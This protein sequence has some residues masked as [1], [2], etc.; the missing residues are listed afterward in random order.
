MEM[1]LTVVDPQRRHGA[2]ELTVR[3]PP[4][5][6]ASDLVPAVARELGRPVQ[7]LQTLY[8]D[9]RALSPTAPVGVPPLVEG[10]VLTFTPDTA[11]ASRGASGLVEVHV[12]GGP[13]AGAVLRL[14]PGR[15]RVGRAAEASI[16][17]EDPG[18]SRVHAELEVS[19]RRRAGARPAVDQRHLARRGPA[20]QHAPRACARQSPGSGWGRPRSWSAPPR[21]CP[22]RP[23]RTG[24]VTSR[25][26]RRPRL[27]PAAASHGDPA[28]CSR[29][30]AATRLALP[31]IAALAAAGAR[32]GDVACPR[33]PH[34]AAVRADEPAHA[35]GQLA[36]RP[37]AGAHHLGPQRRAPRRRPLRQPSR[38][39]TLALLRERDRRLLRHP[40][41][42]SCSRPP[43]PRSRGSGSAAAST[44]TSSLLGR[45][46]H[47][48]RP[49]H[50]VTALPGTPVHA[51]GPPPGA[52]GRSARLGGRSRPDR[53]ARR[54]ASVWPEPS[55]H[56]SCGWHSPRDVSLVSAVRRRLE[57][58]RDWAWMAHLPHTRPGSTGGC[59][60]LVGLL[61]PDSD[62]VQR[63]V[64]EL[65]ALVRTRSTMRGS[66]AAG[67]VLTG[68]ALRRPARRRPAAARP[69]P[70]VSRLLRDGPAAG[71]HFLCLDTEG[72]RL[73][74]E[75][76]RGRAGQPGPASRLTLAVHGAA[77]ST[78]SSPTRSPTA[79]RT[80][81]PAH[82]HGCATPPRTR[83]RPRCPTAARL[84]DLLAPAGL[85]PHDVAGG[86]ESAA[87][88][89]RPCSA[90]PQP[91]PA[92]STC[93]ATGRTPW[94]AGRRARASRSCCRR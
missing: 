93:A 6:T 48:R 42:A 52:G 73:P 33:Q 68:R 12:V 35:P 88:H 27:Q 29:P 51:P 53:A 56:R 23:T 44:T 14:T 49:D 50:R 41:H 62:Q 9:G 75:C 28:A 37:P 3:V 32:R 69:V 4:G 91:D 85:T 76:G 34:H 31:L 72:T 47:R 26:N 66:R 59:R 15:H 78:T 81:S 74:V 84:L 87:L 61:R 36:Q 17:I 45:H 40:D 25:V 55:W 24:R 63:R 16:R 70:G 67:M 7:D 43:R 20:R 94:S 57:L 58:G 89:R 54:D 5:S 83:P 1:H 18:L 13:D 80:G 82:W 86:G 64:A 79:G 77:A 22:R 65:P 60:N 10:V 11:C 38:R 2:L 90:S 19:A 39:S 30:N 8:A 21:P 46:R 71:V 92:L